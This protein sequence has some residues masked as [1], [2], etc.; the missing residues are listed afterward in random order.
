MPH[1]PH[2]GIVRMRSYG[3]FSCSAA[4]TDIGGNKIMRYC[5]LRQKA[6]VNVIEGAQLGYISD[7]EID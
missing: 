6:V 4:Y 3:A 2:F 5:S 7:I 1:R